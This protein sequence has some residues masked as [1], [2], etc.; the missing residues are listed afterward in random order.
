MH[1]HRNLREPLRSGHACGLRAV[2]PANRL[3]LPT[4]VLPMVS[5]RGPCRSSEVAAGCSSPKQVQPRC[6]GSASPRPQCAC[7]KASLAPVPCQAP[8]AEFPRHSW[9]LSRGNWGSGEMRT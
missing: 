2:W 4:P 5:A 3:S 6:P 1:S 8:S 9:A 7:G